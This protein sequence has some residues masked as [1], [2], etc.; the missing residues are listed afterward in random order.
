MK[1]KKKIN[2]FNLFKLQGVC[3]DYFIEIVPKYDFKINTPTGFVSVNFLV[4]KKDIKC[5][6]SS[7]KGNSIKG[8]DKHLVLIDNE[9]KPLDSFDHVEIE[10]QDL[11]D[12]SID[13]PHQ[14]LTTNGIIHHNTTIAKAL[15][16]DLDVNYRYINI[17][18]EGGIDTLRN[19]IKKFAAMKSVN[20][21]P[22]VVICDEFDGASNSLQKGL[23]AAIE[24]F[25]F[26]CRFIL[27]CNYRSQIIEPLRS[28]L[29]E[30]SFD[31]SEKGIKEEMIPLITERLCG[32]L[33]IEGVVFKKETIEKLVDVYFPDIRN[34]L[35]LCQMY[36]KMTKA[37]DDNIFM[38]Q[39]IDE[40]F[41][42][43]I[44]EKKFGK[45]RSYLIEKSYNYSDLFRNLYDNFVPKLPVEKQAPAILVIGE[46]MHQHATSI[47][48]EIN[49]ACCLIELME[50]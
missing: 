33:E 45:A 26:S 49:A 39:Q 8:A 40:E 28:R 31:M 25:R 11:F 44:R 19:D 29:Q 15:C 20:G 9:W 50:L 10:K 41:Y 42:T 36:S 7:I 23:R 12:V 35:K 14:F 21:K 16:Y 37:I 48:P 43:Y 13:H 4:K 3:D 46:F 38:F 30:V 32:I 47:D 1:I 27:T 18:S 2:L 34:M 22:K 6:N 17:S 5:V 24:E